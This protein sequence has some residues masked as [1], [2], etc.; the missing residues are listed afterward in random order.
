M[1]TL[2]LSAIVP[3]QRFDT[4]VLAPGG[5]D[6]PVV[7]LAPGAPMSASMLEALRRSGVTRVEIPEAE[8]TEPVTVSSE[9]GVES[10]QEAREDD[11]GESAW[12]LR[13]QDRQRAFVRER[14]RQRA[15]MR[16]HAA[17]VV[18]RSTERWSRL[19]GRAVLASDVGEPSLAPAP[20]RGSHLDA[21]DSEL[22]STSDITERI[23]LVQR[24]YSRL[25][26]GE[27]VHAGT[28]RTLADEAIAL[29]ERAGARQVGAMAVRIARAGDGLCQHAYAL[30]LLCVASASRMGWRRDDVRAAGLAAL[31]ADVGMGVL[32]TN[33]RAI[34]RPLTDLERCA[35][36]AHPVYGAGLL[37]RVVA[38]DQDQA[39]PAIVPVAVLQHHE[40]EDGR[41]YPAGLRSEALCDLAK[42]IAACDTFLGLVSPRAHRPGLSGHAAVTTLVR[43]ATPRGPMDHAC[44]RAVVET[45]GVFP[46]GQGV[47]LSSGVV[48][49]VVGLP[50]HARADRPTVMIMPAGSRVDLSRAP[51]ETIKAAAWAA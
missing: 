48:G 9:S 31:L 51:S 2:E 8:P 22:L 17:S 14:A 3:G 6:T 15:A 42:L 23:A 26:S 10:A 5:Q 25:A 33:V 39:L 37:E 16:T 24:T 29:V 45:V 32:T 4:P 20:E 44:V 46:A 13:E 11:D 35:L 21:G 43:S 12:S 38:P 27:T 40:R 7:L 41:G 18:A 47:R 30:M 36:R 19:D 50:E 34:D 28:V 49:L 1:A